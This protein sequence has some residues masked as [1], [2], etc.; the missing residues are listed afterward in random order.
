MKPLPTLYSEREAAEL[1]GISAKTLSREAMADRVEFYQFGTRRRY[2]ADQLAEYLETKRSRKPRPR[3][4][5]L[6]G[7][8]RASQR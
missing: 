2:S 1:L 5:Q 8:E 7:A 4:V 3:M 6:N